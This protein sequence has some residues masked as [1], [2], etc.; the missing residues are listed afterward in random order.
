MS[1]VSYTTKKIIEVDETEDFDSV[2]TVKNGAVAQITKEKAKQALGIDKLSE[3]ITDLKEN[4]TGGTADKDTVVHDAVGATFPPSQKPASTDFDGYDIDVLNAIADDVYSYIDGIVGDEKT[5]TKEIL[6]KDASGKYDIARYIYANR[7]HIAWQRQNYPKMYAWANENDVM[8][9]ESVSPRIGEKAFEVPYVQTSEKQV[10]TVPGKAAVL[11]GKRYSLSGG[12]FKDNSGTAAIV[13]P[14][15]KNIEGNVTIK[16]VNMQRNSAYGFVYGGEN[17]SVFTGTI[18]LEVDTNYTEFV[19]RNDYT[20]ATYSPVSN[21]SF[22]TFFVDSTGVDGQYANSKILVDGVEVPFEITTDPAIAVQESTTV[23]EVEGGGSEITGASATNRSRTINGLEFVRYESG[24][25]EPTIIFTDADDERN[26]N[27]SIVK[28]GITYDRY[29]LGDLG[30]NRKKLIPIFVYA[31][32]HGIYPIALDESSS[33]YNKYETKM[34][35]LVAARMLRDFASGKQSGNS[36]YKYI[37][38]N[39]MLIVIPVAN[40]FGFNMNVTGDT[41]A[42]SN[43][44]QNANNCNINRNYDTKGWDITKANE[45]YWA[46]AYAGSEN[47]T[48]YIMNTMVECGAKVAMSLHGLSGWAGY[49][50]HQGQ[51]PDG[52]DY[53]REKL[54]KIDT[55]L[56]DNYGYN[57]RY[58]DLN[59]D[60]TPAVVVNMPDNTSKSPSYIT[61]CGAYG[62]IVEF[63]PDDVTTSGFSHEMKSNVIENAYAQT[64][65]LLAMWLSD[66][67]ESK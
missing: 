59:T 47:E 22:V 29:P 67:L 20:D 45:S 4:G 43:G 41:N 18:L 13:L 63:S 5:V 23:V 3:E 34:C 36:L 32:E 56:K 12:S 33:S 19:L 40:P 64:I 38:E 11:V 8:Y 65:N 14:L 21:Y 27:A 39:C 46:G 10:V 6:G 1:D 66:Y 54:A 28:D 62:G 55:F 30:A 7:E 26:I 57:L 35:A 60:G 31:N 2:V 58:Y 48:Q 24:D 16:L 44:Y 37:R 52:G 25:I 51:S 17:P 53:N 9:T 42:S 15:P 49:C 50:A 61:Q